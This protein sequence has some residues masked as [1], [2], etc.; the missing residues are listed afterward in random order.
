MSGDQ[1]IHGTDWMAFFSS[2]ALTWHGQHSQAHRSRL[3]PEGDELLR[4]S[5][6]SSAGCLAGSVLSSA[7]VMTEMPTSPT[8]KT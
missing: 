7:S 3:L 6:F 2:E 1:Q 4:A 5:W 8:G